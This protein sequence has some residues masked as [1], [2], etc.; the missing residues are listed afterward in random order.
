MQKLL[1][2]VDEL[3]LQIPNATTLNTNVSV[4]DIGWHIEHSCLV[5]IKITETIQN[6]NPETYRPRFSFIKFIVLLTGKFP[7]GRAKAPEVVMPIENIT[8]SHLEK[9]II[10]AKDAIQELHGC[11][12]NNYFNHPFF[13]NLNTPATINFLG[14]HTNHHLSII[15]DILKRF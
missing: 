4:G 8:I 7:R 2:L 10:L 12:K 14:I 3:A 13:G 9:S 11:E 5:I 6:S 1:N 15:K